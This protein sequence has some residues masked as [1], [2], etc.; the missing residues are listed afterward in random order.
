MRFERRQAG[1]GWPAGLARFWCVLVLAVWIAGGMAAT[2]HAQNSAFKDAELDQMLAPIALY[3]DALLSQ[4]LMACTYPADVAAAAEWS[5]AHPDMKGDAAVKQVESQAWEASVKSLVAFPQ[6][7]AMMRQKPGDVQRL[8]DAFLADPGRVM[9]RVQVLRKQAQ[10]A[11]NLQTTSQ[12]QVTTQTEASKQVI[13]IVPAQPQTVY[14]PVYQPTVVYGSWIDPTYPPNYWPPPPQHYPPSSGAFVAGVFWGAAIVGVSDSLW[15]GFN[16]GGNDVNI[17]VNRY[18]NVNVNKQITN[19]NNT[20]VHNPER[21]GDVPYRDSKS[22]EQYGKGQLEGANEREAFRGK[23][24]AKDGQRD[25]RDADRAKA[26]ETT[27]ARGVDPAAGR[28][29]QQGAD[30]DKAGQ[31]VGDKQ[32]GSSNGASTSALTGVGDS[33]ASRADADRGR[34]SRESIASASASQSAPAARPVPQSRP[35]PAATPVPASKPSPGARSGGG[36]GLRR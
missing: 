35:A 11:G 17:N 31:G 3:P 19:N 10:Q 33:G 16:W 32:R 5:K 34:S 4:I 27:K 25:A 8:G 36:D 1:I 30:R 12:Q 21:R 22:R 13:V 24:G 18:N 9:D 23:E 7:L 15:G 28:D 6:V 29:I 2:A 20:F 14:V 26:A